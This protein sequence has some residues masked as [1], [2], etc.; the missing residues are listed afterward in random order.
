MRL[1]SLL[2]SLR[3]SVSLQLTRAPRRAAGPRPRLSWGRVAAPVPGAAA[4]RD[5]ARAPGRG[6]GARMSL[7]CAV[8][9][10]LAMPRLAA[11]QADGAPAAAPASRPA[12]EPV[13][14]ARAATAAPRWGVEAELVQ[15]WIPTVHI[16]TA[17]VV[18]TLWSR[19]GGAR[20]DLRVGVYLRPRVD[21]DIVET[22]DEYLL[23]AG[24]RQY[25]WRGLHLDVGVLAGWAYG[26]RNKIDGMD[27]SNPAVLV[28]GL[29][30]YRAVLW[31]PQRGV[32]VYVAPQVGVLAGVMT[33][34]GPRGGKSDV[35]AEAKLLVG[36][37][38]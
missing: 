2:A 24:Y 8:L 31:R 3:L 15:P 32:G 9:V 17:Q 1:L 18:R 29:A 6:A 25:V 33:D 12:R 30:G 16:F 13:L 37:T 27:Y 23:T 28:E 26:T 20:G 5:A 36:M 22:I 14:E 4:A 35:F 19:A 34:I 21:H 7:A 38:F 10:A 11:A